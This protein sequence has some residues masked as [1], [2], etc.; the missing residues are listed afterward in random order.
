MPGTDGTEPVRL[1]AVLAPGLSRWL[2]LVKWVLLVPHLFVLLFLWLAFGLASIAAFFAILITGRYPRSLFD[3]NLGVLRWTW[4]VGYYGYG[5]LGTDRYPPFT[6]ADDPDYPARLDIAYPEQL[7]RGLVLVKWWLLAVPQYVVVG[8]FVGGAGAGW[9][10]TD[11]TAAWGSGGLIGVLVLV[12]A[13]TLAFT[14]T[15]PRPLFDFVLGL[16]RW[17]VRVV[18]YAAL[19]TDRYP[20]FR[21][22][23]GGSESRPQPDVQPAAPGEPPVGPVAVGPPSDGSVAP[24]TAPTVPSPGW[25]AGRIAAVSLGALLAL[26][27]IGMLAGGGALAWLDH[28]Q[29]D[30]A[31][32][33]TSPERTFASSSYAITTDRIDLGST[34][35]VTPS[36]FLGTIRIRATST[37]PTRPVFVAIGPQVAVDRYLQGVGRATI[38][39]WGGRS[40]DYRVVGG[41]APPV[42]PTAT[43]IWVRS[44]TGTGT[45]TIR[46]KP[47]GGAW[48]VVVMRPDGTQGVSVT[49]DVGA[50]VPP[51]RWVYAGILAVGGLLLIGSGVLIVVPIVLAGRRPHAGGG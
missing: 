24:V 46:W 7:S 8:I 50:T 11:R 49:A 12:A 18:A 29:R 16:Q 21:L 42:P 43:R 32:F 37:D 36:S 34:T 2:W 6:L 9:G 22:D 19:M 51:L 27:S 17:T 20:P 1:E 31:G 25:T 41:S 10:S 4:R 40:A 28:S 30:V 15:Y 39:A 33:L 48:T 38:T 5:V 47:T 45:Q 26:V 35:D 23:T 13:V 44:A 3:F 14:G